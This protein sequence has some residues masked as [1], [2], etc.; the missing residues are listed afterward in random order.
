MVA[1]PEEEQLVLPGFRGH[2]TC[3]FPWARMDTGKIRLD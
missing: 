2:Q 3:C 1:K